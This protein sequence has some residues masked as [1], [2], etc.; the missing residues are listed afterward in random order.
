MASASISMLFGIHQGCAARFLIIYAL[1]MMLLPGQLSAMETASFQVKHIQLEEAKDLAATQLS[2]EGRLSTLASRSL[3]IAVDKHKNIEK[4]R[5]LLQQFDVPSPKLLLN[6]Q[7]LAVSTAQSRLWAEK[8]QS[9]PGGWILVESAVSDR[10]RL[11][12][13]KEAWLS[14]NSKTRIETGSIR[15]VRLEIRQWLEHHGVPDTPDLA[16]HPIT[17]GFAFRTSLQHGN[18][19]KLE[20]N[21]W[22]KATQQ[23]QISAQAH[24]E[25][26]PDLGTTVTTLQPPSTTAPIRLNI[27]P[28]SEVSQPDFIDI[29]EANIE[30][31]MP[32]GEEITLLADEK[33]ARALGEAL[34][35]KTINGQGKRIIFR[36]LLKQQP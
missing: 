11:M 24:V 35:S 28:V 17:A 15:P 25:V 2:D 8:G 27:Q 12:T 29:T 3:L 26:L 34:L 16:L 1:A 33:Q 36:L 6:L 20:L 32:I 31:D 19:V 10:A 14:S 7:V 5:K 13:S 9:L 30:I 4:I 21:P 18:R 22:I 23:A